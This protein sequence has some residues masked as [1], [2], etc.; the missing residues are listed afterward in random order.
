MEQ[1]SSGA[2]SLRPWPVFHSKA[3]VLK[4]LPTFIDH[5][6]DS[7]LPNEMSS[8]ENI[9]ELCKCV[10]FFATFYATFLYLLIFVW[11]TMCTRT[12]FYD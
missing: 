1:I 4:S 9:A 12:L 3:C 11:E 7:I 5:F 6:S 8:I 2:V 10:A